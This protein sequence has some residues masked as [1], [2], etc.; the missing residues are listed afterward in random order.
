[1]NHLLPI[2]KNP[3]VKMLPGYAQPLSIIYARFKE[4]DIF[5]IN[6]FSQ[7]FVDNYVG[8]DTQEFNQFSTRFVVGFYLYN[9]PFSDV[10]NIKSVSLENV[11]SM[12]ALDIIK[13]EINND[14]YVFSTLNEFFIPGTYFYKKVNMFHTE[15]IYG[16]DDELKLL[17]GFVYDDNP[18]YTAITIKYED[19]EKA[20]NK[21]DVDLKF[22]T[23]YTLKDNTEINYNYEI[24]KQTLYEY[25][26]SQH[27]SADFDNSNIILGLKV[28]DF[29]LSELDKLPN[30]RIDPRNFAA[31]YEHKTIMLKRIKE[32]MKLPKLAKDYE[33]VV[34]LSIGAR[35][36]AFQYYKN[37]YN[38]EIKRTL[39]E[40]ICQMKELENNILLDVYSN[41][42]FENSNNLKEFSID[43]KSLC[44]RPYSMNSTVKDF[45]NDPDVWAILDEYLPNISK[46][47]QL[48]LV[49]GMKIKKVIGLA[50]KYFKLTDEQI[51]E[52]LL[53][54]FSLK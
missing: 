54:V 10:F 52:I 19:F 16:Y 7:L 8:V 15:L 32:Y 41:L 20:Y 28:Y 6:N 33:K 22:F 26:Y 5:L 21:T 13:N 39:I 51:N 43:K 38:E 50:K 12:D 29:I 49:Y 48:S 45:A 37:G 3:P 11:S 9:N 27:G 47:S 25:I 18:K 46:V 2:E 35:T 1:M 14:N 30:Q 24:N 53:K 17:Y 31:L 40:I 36:R 44:Y 23:T 4:P 42:D 34:M